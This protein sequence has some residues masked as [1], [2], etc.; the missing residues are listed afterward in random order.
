[1]LLVP[2][3]VIRALTLEAAD[4]IVSVDKAIANRFTWTSSDARL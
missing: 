1:M 3:R 4:S 2:W